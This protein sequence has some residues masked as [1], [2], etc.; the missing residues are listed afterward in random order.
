MM[1]KQTDAEMQEHKLYRGETYT[2]SGTKVNTEDIQL[3]KIHY[4]LT[5]EGR[6]EDTDSQLTV[7][8]TLLGNTSLPA[9]R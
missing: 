2:D 8:T 5:I 3:G 9:H 1:R 7:D 6:R 4:R